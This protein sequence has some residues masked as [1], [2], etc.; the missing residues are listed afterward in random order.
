VPGRPQTGAATARAGDAVTL[1]PNSKR[2]LTKAI[3]ALIGARRSEASATTIETAS[4]AVRVMRHH[5]SRNDLRPLFEM[6]E[7]SPGQLDSYIDDGEVFV[8]YTHSVLVGHVQVVAS[9][10]DS[11]EIKNIAV[12]DRYRRQ[13]VSCTLVAKAIESSRNQGHR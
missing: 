13:G 5:G 8:A 7:D 6:A 10:D 1:G 11:A 3:D 12:A 9:D 4:P 2:E